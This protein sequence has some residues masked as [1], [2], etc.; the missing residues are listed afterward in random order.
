MEGWISIHRKSFENP[1]YFSEKFTVWQA[2]VDLILLACH[3]PKTLFVRGI[4]V[5]LKRGE[6]FWSQKKLASRWM[7]S[8]K[9]VKRV[10]NLFQKYEQIVYKVRHRIG[11]ITVVNY[12]KY[13]N[14]TPQ[15]TPQST[16]QKT[17]KLR[18]NNNVNKG[19][20]VN[21]KRGRTYKST[22]T[23]KAYTLEQVA[24]AIL[25]I[26]N[27]EMGTRFKSITPFLSG[28]EFWSETYAP[29]EIEEAVKQIPFHHFWKDKMT[30]TMLF[31][32]R[33]PRGESVD[34]LG[35]LINSRRKKWNQ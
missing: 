31:R 32:R 21:K 20:N 8:D 9:K 17:H 1:L 6:L 18:P 7:W 13:Q 11:V 27:Q 4:E 29:N 14:T 5:K 10:L 3:K 12:D 19:N 25:K 26:F 35:E 30:P 22:K 2:W 34:Y 15:T 28:L 23:D 16:P 33:N 24:L